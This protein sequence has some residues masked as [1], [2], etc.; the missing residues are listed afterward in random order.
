MNDLPNERGDKHLETYRGREGTKKFGPF[1]LD[2]VNQCL[3]RLAED[4]SAEPV[5]LRPKAFDL[6]RYLV[7]HPGRL[8]T[9]DELLDALWGDTPVQPEVLKGHIQAIRN[10]MGDDAQCPRF[11]ETY[12]GRGYRFIAT[13]S[14][15]GVAGTLRPFREHGALV[16][17]N[18]ELKA[19]EN[20]LADAEAGRPQIVF[21][22][23]EAG[24][25]KTALV[26]EFFGALAERPEVRATYGRCIEGFSG[27]APYYVALEAMTRLV[28]DPASEAALD[29]L[30]AVAP[31]WANQLHGA[32]SR[33]QRSHLQSHLDHSTKDRM[34]GEFIDLIE[35]LATDN[36]FLLLLEDLHWAD[37]STID[38]LSAIARRRSRA[39]LMIVATYRPED[40]E[41]DR[42][43]LRHLSHDLAVHCLSREIALRPLDETAIEEFLNL[44]FPGWSNELTGMVFQHSGGNPLFMVAM[45]DHLVKLGAMAHVDG[46]WQP[47]TALVDLPF[48]VPPSLSSLI[49]SRIQRLDARQQRALEAASV[50]GETFNALAPAVAAGISAHHF[51]LVCEELAQRGSF[52]RRNDIE[53][54]ANGVAVR[55]YGFVHRLYRNV[56]LDRQGPLQLAQSLSLIGKELENAARRTIVGPSP[57]NFCANCKAPETGT[58]HAPA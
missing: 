28:K 36:V 56:L 20:A 29:L 22:T 17:R 34:L 24:I 10:A 39:K 41:I 25:G 47:L 32:M 5:K 51:E 27:I 6:L 7:E 55:Q 53:V 58:K 14:G 26:E 21:V 45:L 9:H 30:I 35:T 57:L 48:A 38:L 37:Y 23:G 12:R 11:I 19:L 49:E 52:I 44:P 42:P 43:S 8:V 15:D 3:F 33:E 1:L 16:G 46:R 40:A 31:A 2:T 50:A 18:D 4:G 13:L 54:L